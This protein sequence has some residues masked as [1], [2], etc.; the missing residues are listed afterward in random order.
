MTALRMVR[1][2]LLVGEKLIKKDEY[3]LLRYVAV[4]AQASIAGQITV[5][6]DALRDARS[7]WWGG[8][9]SCA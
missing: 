8:V 9:K 5:Q 2:I 3:P 1:V 4:S 7:F 6:V